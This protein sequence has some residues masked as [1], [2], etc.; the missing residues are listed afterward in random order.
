M[1]TTRQGM[2][3]IALLLLLATG[4]ALRADDA[5]ARAVNTIEKLGGTVT[6]GKLVVGEFV[7]DVVTEV[8]HARCQRVTD[9]HLKELA[10]L[11]HLQILDL[12]CTNITDDGLKE[13]ARLK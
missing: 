8:N 11:K 5:K 12:Q 13:L 7:F 9:T 6:Y 2:T 4:S 3:V 10:A 1:R